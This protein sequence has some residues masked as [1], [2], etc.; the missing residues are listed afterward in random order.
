MEVKIG[1]EKATRTVVEYLKKK[2]IPVQDENKIEQV[3]TISANND[4]MIGSLIAEAMRTV[5]NDGV[6]TV[7]EAQGIDTSLEVVEGMQFEKGFISPYLVTDQERMTAEFDEPYILITD[8]K[9][10]N[11]KQIVPV[12]ERIANEGRPLLIIADEVEGEALAALIL[13]SMRGTIKVSA[14]KAPGFGDEKKEMLEDIAVI[15]GGTVISEDKGMNFDNMSEGMLGKARKVTVT[16]ENTTIVEGKGK[17]ENIDKRK[18]LID[19]QLL[20]TDSEYKKKDLEKRRARL[21]RGIGVLKVGA[22]TET[23]M[24]EKKMRI[25]DALHA[26][27]AAIEEGVI[28]GG[29]TMLYRSI[30]VL[31]ELKLEGDQKIGVAIVRKALLSPLRQ[32]AENAGKEGAEV[33]AKIAEESE[34]VGYNAKTDVYED[35]LKAGVIDPTKVVRSGLQNASS[36]AAMVLTTEA[37]VADYDEDKDKAGPAIII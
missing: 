30:K 37:L 15:T 34:N 2:S 28:A 32:I 16:D 7:E 24:K 13:N 6:I 19:A 10:S 14:V 22:A 21:G 9:I 31:D 25:D 18:K 11:L 17:K 20:N 27:K 35:L 26:T 1:I 33:I 23:E 4:P 29:G 8:K 5:G 3:A 36:I 12:L